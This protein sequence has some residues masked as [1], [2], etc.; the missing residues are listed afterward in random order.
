MS[1]NFSVFASL[2]VINWNILT[3]K[4]WNLFNFKL[5]FLNFKTYQKYHL[6]AQEAK[7]ELLTWK[8]RMYFSNLKAREPHEIKTEVDF[9]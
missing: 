2:P 6:Y 3:A 4:V 1:R 7:R 9:S 8:R 5:D